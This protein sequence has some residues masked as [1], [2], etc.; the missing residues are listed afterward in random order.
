MPSGSDT[1]DA[2]WLQNKFSEEIM[3]SKEKKDGRRFQVQKERPKV[4]G[5]MSG[6]PRMN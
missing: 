1:A 6:R 2:M 3:L 5:I 4:T